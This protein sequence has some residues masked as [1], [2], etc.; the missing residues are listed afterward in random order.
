MPFSRGGYG[1]SFR[2]VATFVENN[3]CVKRWISKYAPAPRGEWLSGTRLGN[4]R[5]L[6]RFFKW[7]HVVKDIDLSPGAL[8]NL[9]LQKRQSVSVEDRQWLLSL[10]LEH[11][12]DNPEF[13]GL[14]DGRKYLIF[15]IIKNFCDFHEVP[16]TTAK[17]IFGRKR[18]KNHRKQISL[19]EAK[20]IL[21]QLP[22]RDRAICLIQLQS[23]MEIGAVLNKLNY[24]WHNQVKPQLDEGRPR[25]RIEFNGRKGSDRWYF[26]YI[27]RDAVV[28]LKKWLLERRKIVEKRIADNKRVEK[29]V[30]EGEPIFITSRATPLRSNQFLRQF[31][32]K[33]EGKVTTHMFRKLF[34]TEASIPERGID[35]K[36]VEF[37]MGHINGIDAVGAEYDRTPEV[38]EEAFEAEYRKLEPFINIYSSSVAIRRV[39]PLLQDIEQLTQLPGGRQF[40]SGLVKDAKAKLAKMLEQQE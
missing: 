30:I 40:F 4:A 2:E 8:L 33:M 38:Y 3:G 5:M 26:T 18:R 28:E 14:S 37:F 21:G 17:G 29:A 27:S 31:N 13:R 11:S 39:D 12:R 35:R 22:T 10:V 36:I 34:K 1:A 32:R 25:V 20:E 19:A 23:G 7:L 9:Q 15:C 16:L 24:M 6:F